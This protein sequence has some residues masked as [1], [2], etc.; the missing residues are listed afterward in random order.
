MEPSRLS[1]LF[2]TSVGGL[3]NLFSAIS[4]PTVFAYLTIGS[5]ILGARLARARRVRGLPGQLENFRAS[6][7]ALAGLLLASTLL[8]IRLAG[9][10]VLYMGSAMT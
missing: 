1:R 10:S 9:A 8:T 7:V 3:L 6:H 2:S 4:R 5:L